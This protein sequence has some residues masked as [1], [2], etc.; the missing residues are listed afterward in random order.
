MNKCMNLKPFHH[1]L[2]AELYI[3]GVVAALFYGSALFG[4]QNTL[5]IPVGVLSLLVLSVSAMA[6]L[7]FARPLVY[8][9]GGDPKAAMGFF[10]KTWGC[11]AVLTALVFVGMFFQIRFS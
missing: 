7:F 2:L 4:P 5:L 11:F 3:A 6:F 8:L 9:I 1:A 10:L